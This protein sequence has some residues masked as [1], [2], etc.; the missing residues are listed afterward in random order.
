MLCC[1]LR[2]HEIG[3]KLLQEASMRSPWQYVLW[4]LLFNFLLVHYLIQLVHIC[5]SHPDPPNPYRPPP[6]PVPHPV[7]RAVNTLKLIR[8]VHRIH[9]MIIFV[10]H[11]QTKEF[12]KRFYFAFSFHTYFLR[13]IPLNTIQCRQQ[14]MYWLGVIDGR[15]QQIRAFPA[16]LHPCCLGCPPT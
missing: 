10:Y 2:E 15:C 9:V 13:D 14:Q 8:H 3:H 12:N 1:F 7:V 4:L 11:I 6:L 16:V 5:S